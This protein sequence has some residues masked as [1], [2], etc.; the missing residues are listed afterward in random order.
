[1]SDAP[2]LER[3][4]M[5]DKKPLVGNMLSVNKDQPLQSLMQL[6]RELGPIFRMDMMGTP[7]VVAS[8]VDLVR[9][10]CD[11]T[12]FDKAVRGSLRR[13]RAIGG[14]GLFTGDT[15]EPNWSKAHNILLPTF[16][17][18]AMSNYMPM[19]LD[20]AGQL[21]MKW[22]RMNGDDEIDV[23][24][25]MTAVAL[26]TIGICGFN[27]RFNSFYRQDYHPFIDALTNTLE[28]CMMQ[29]GLPFESTLLKRRLDNMKNDVGYMNQLVDNI[30][31]E[32]RQGGDRAENDLLNYMLD[33][34]DKV[35]GESLS[36][37]NI[38]YQINTFLIAGHETTS[39]LMSFTMHFLMNH[40]EVLAKAYEEVDRVLGRDISVQP[41]LKQV[42]QLT[43]VNQLILEALRLYPTAPAFSVYP[44]KDEVIG[45]KYK[46]KERTFTT[47]LILM[48]HRDKSVW[49]EDAELFNPDNFSKEA[50]AER[51]VDAYKPFGNGQRA[52]IGRQFAMQEA[53]L[54]VGMILQ[55][56]ELIN[57]TNYELKVKESMSVKPDGFK[58]RVR[59]RK[60][61]T[62]SA[63]V[64]GASTESAAHAGG[65]SDS[66][67][68]PTHGTPALVLYGSNLGTTE[69]YARDLAR[70][71]DAAGFDVTLAPMD[72][73]ADKLPR[74][75]AVIIACA[76]YNGAPPDNAQAFVE[77]LEN[78]PAGAAEGVKYAVFG[79]GHSDWAAT[80]QATPRYLDERLE[81]L[82]GAR[83]ITK[84][85]G[86]ARDDIDEQFE[87]WAGAL[88]PQ[89]GDALGLDLDL[90]QS[91]MAAPLYEAEVLSSV[92]MNPVLAQAGAQPVTVRVNR[93]LQNTAASNRSTRH[94]EVALNEGMTYRAGD[95]LSV[96]P[97]NPDALV[98][99]VLRRFGYGAETQLR[100][101][102]S[103]AEHSQLPVGTAMSA[104]RL[105]TDLVELQ[106]PASRKD[107]ATLAR[108]TECP[109]SAPALQALAGDGYKGDVQQKRLS[110]LDVLDQFPACE[111]PFGVFLELM[112]MLAPRYY[113]ISSS[114][115]VDAAHCSITVGVVD[116]PAISGL[117]QFTGICSNY[118]ANTPE[119]TVMHASLRGTSDGF[120]LPDDPK[121]PVIMIGPGTGIAPFRGFLH[122]RAHLKA[123]GTDLGPA[124]MVFGCRHPDQDYIYRDE[125]EGFAKDAVADLHVAFSR[126]DKTKT[127]VQDLIRRERDTVWE[128]I[129]N[130][131]K[132]FVCGDG[133]RME[134]DVRRA[135]ILIYCEEMDVGAQAGEA[136][137]DQMTS[138]ARYV[139]DVWVSN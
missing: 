24:H 40:P 44:Y 71:A 112:P 77:W 22:E 136:W 100:L 42:N 138:D 62:R 104:A 121:T 87:T 130:G 14:D 111:L 85:E 57:H 50:I 126:Q 106:S 33:G 122:E 47:V 73:Y 102:S 75:G 91:E 18:Q 107:I 56:F 116:E 94:I 55:R 58:M 98:A 128:M 80:F 64:P 133:S 13:V 137:M 109:K 53:V 84:A 12:R 72:D 101:R 63:L 23:V 92:E 31:A 103:A 60:G 38:R 27:Y 15:Q 28:T 79:C 115:Q 49:G 45:G 110:V 43:Y 68:R 89:V 99:R 11:E 132:I 83:M 59:M 32:R 61:V 48:L 35:T 105:L 97:R 9:E 82:G 10:L 88:W 67:S 131:A 118:L 108:H 4:P 93:E 134:P 86:D 54:V 19:M 119:G 37:E 125:L 8:G 51:P 17:R 135:L 26:D 20:V 81:A 29:R 39:G 114:P 123:A 1:M 129:Q 117:G 6:T 7:L 16:S 30:I 124:L 69:D 76:S 21:C 25:D 74:S 65:L 46:L 96:V 70:S 139:L 5:P 41:T 90:S 95:H 113:S 120:R 66:A 127:Y 34:V 36:D 52:C 78:A 3:I 2:N